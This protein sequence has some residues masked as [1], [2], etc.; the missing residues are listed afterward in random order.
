MDS[1]GKKRQTNVRCPL[2]YSL[3]SVLKQFVAVVLGYW[4][5]V[6]VVNPA[7]FT[8]GFGGSLGVVCEPGE[9]FE[10]LMKRGEILG[11]CCG[12]SVVIVPPFICTKERDGKCG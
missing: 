12:V 2:F 8:T 1:K 4:N 7:D 5:I 11:G 9:E 6:P 10:S 3:N